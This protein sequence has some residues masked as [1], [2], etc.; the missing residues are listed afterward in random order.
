VVLPPNTPWCPAASDPPLPPSCWQSF[1]AAV[2]QLKH[3]VLA[4]YYAVHD[5]RTPWLS[6]ILP[7]LVLAYALSPLDLIPDFIPVL[8]FLDD[9]LLLPL[10]LWLSYKL[11]PAEV[12]GCL[13]SSP[14]GG[15]GGWKVV[16]VGGW[17]GAGKGVPGGGG[18]GS[19]GPHGLGWCRPESFLLTPFGHVPHPKPVLR[20][21]DDVLLLLALSRSL[22]QKSV[23]GVKSCACVLACT[24][25]NTETF[26]RAGR[27]RAL[28][29]R[30][31]GGGLCC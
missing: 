12:G 20:V 10:G 6:K 19:S 29:G 13:L 31:R 25:M 11:I 27:G 7:W 17:G 15:G 5:P 30:G 9:M 28:G 1:K 24:C 2:K 4:L 16:W 14:G 23:S 18:G 8:G 22:Q 21:L 26:L 3:D